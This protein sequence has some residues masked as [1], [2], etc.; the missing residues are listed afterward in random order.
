MNQKIK[1][2]V[3]AFALTAVVSVFAADVEAEEAEAQETQAVGWT[4]FALSIA[5]PVQL[6]WGLAKWDVFG[7]DL[8][9]FY[10]DSPNVYGLDVSLA[11]TVREEFAG[12]ALGGLFN[13][14]QGD[15]YGMRGTLG[16][17]MSN[18]SVYGFD[19]GGIGIHRNIYGVDAELVCGIQENIVGAQFSLICNLTKEESYG[20][21]FS[22][23]NIAKTAY[24]AQ[25]GFLYNHA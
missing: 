20:A 23:V 19:A 4:P 15:A 17:N 8:G 10:N 13:F 3:A 2:G 22:G 12:L 6:P 11:N 1:V 16:V 24:G 14:S 7:L 5:S 9:I 25:V 18:A 21:T